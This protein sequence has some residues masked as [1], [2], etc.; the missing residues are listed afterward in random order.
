MRVFAISFLVFFVFG[1]SLRQTKVDFVIRHLCR[2]KAVLGGVPRRVRGE[3][4]VQFSKAKM[5]FQFFQSMPRWLAWSGPSFHEGQRVL[6]PDEALAGEYDDQQGEGSFILELL[7][8]LEGRDCQPR[9]PSF[10]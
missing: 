8:L 9:G 3:K 2:M 4:S 5:C 10:I 1:G 6:G 7:R